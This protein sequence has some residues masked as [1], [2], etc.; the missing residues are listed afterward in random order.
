MEGRCNEQEVRGKRISIV[1]GALDVEYE[2]K[3]KINLLSLVKK[4]HPFK[5]T[6]LYLLNLPSAN[7]SRR[8]SQGWGGS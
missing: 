3:T 8:V 2:V 6:T 1:L 5:E 7:P 4:T